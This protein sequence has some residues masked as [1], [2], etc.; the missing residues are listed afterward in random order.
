MPSLVSK[1]KHIACIL[2]TLSAAVVLA[3]REHVFAIVVELRNVS[4]TYLGVWLPSVTPT[5]QLSLALSQMTHTFALAEIDFIEGVN[6]A[7]PR[8]QG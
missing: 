8:E 7:D 6:S 1:R 3:H 4:F 2:L 5:S